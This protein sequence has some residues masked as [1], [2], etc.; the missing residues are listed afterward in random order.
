MGCGS[1]KEG[2]GGRAVGQKYHAAQHSN[3]GHAGDDGMQMG[4][5]SGGRACVRGV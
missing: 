3:F 4:G 5:I 2:Q 1:S